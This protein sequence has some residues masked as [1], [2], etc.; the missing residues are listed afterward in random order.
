MKKRKDLLDRVSVEKPCAA[1]WDK[2]FGNDEVRFCEHCAKSV[3]NLSAMTHKDAERLVKKSNGNL[4]IRYYTDKNKKIA[5]RDAPVQI[6]RLGR[7]V[8]QF[9]ASIFTAALSVSAVAAQGSARIASENQPAPVQTN[10]TKINQS[11]S[12][13]ANLS[14]TITDPNG[15][16]IPNVTVT[17]FDGQNNKIATI[18]SNDEGFYKFDALAE[19]IYNLEF[20][21]IAGFATHKIENVQISSRKETTEDAA[22]TLSG[23]TVTMGVVATV[24]LVNEWIYHSEKRAKINVDPAEKTLDF[25]NNVMSDN[26]D[27]VKTALQ[28][29]TF[30]D[31]EMPEGAT[32]LM[33]A[34]S[35]KMAKFLIKRGANPHAQT[36]Y[37]ETAL[38]LN[39]GNPEM[40][41]FFLSRGL[42]VNATSSFGVTPLMYSMQFNEIESV[43]LLL[44]A[45]ADSNISDVEGRTAL[46][47]AVYESKLEIIK[48]LV[49]SGANVNA[50]DNKGKTVLMYAIEGYSDDEAENIRYLIENGADA[51]ARNAEG[52]SILKLAIEEENEEAIKLLKSYGAI[53]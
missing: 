13:A 9:A 51:N 5:L 39:A 46:M 16:V 33:Y 38:M 53:E 35:P 14:G 21:A 24:S 43:R 4:C 22:M 20:S 15:A 27:E 47:L 23:E 45:G 30:V 3:H 49:E 36:L 42:K 2:M 31:V 29:K 26:F 17:L 19:G 6:T 32:P 44:N 52:N 12:G 50:R 1:D 7:R 28:N 41:K 10:E 40:V 25:F 18:A 37:G 34:G 8:S 48:L 11:K